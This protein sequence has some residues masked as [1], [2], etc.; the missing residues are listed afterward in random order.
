MHNTDRQRVTH[1]RFPV[2]SHCILQPEVR[3]L[4]A[5]HHQEPLVGA[6]KCLAAS[7]HPPPHLVCQCHQHIRHPKRDHNNEPFCGAKYDPVE[8]RVGH[9]PPPHQ[10]HC[11]RPIITANTTRH[12]RT[13]LM[14]THN[15]RHRIGGVFPSPG[16]S[17]GP[18]LWDLGAECCLLARLLGQP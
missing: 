6:H 12:R 3:A 2:P 13:M 8:P 9:E 1:Q 18:S 10:H 7:L 16:P 14:T 17:L 4:P 15:R 5:P 11:Q